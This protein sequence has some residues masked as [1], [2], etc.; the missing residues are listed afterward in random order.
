MSD[1]A[2]PWTAACQAF[3]SSTIIWS[4]LKLVS[5][6]SVMLSNY[7]ILC[8]P[9]LLPSIFPS[10]RIFSSESALHIRYLG[11]VMFDYQ[12]VELL[13]GVH[14]AKSTYLK[15]GGITLNCT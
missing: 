11:S 13:S 6:E 8:C 10:I 9:L 1:S 12:V 14:L 2:T 15:F 7:L 3:L 5:I 4:L